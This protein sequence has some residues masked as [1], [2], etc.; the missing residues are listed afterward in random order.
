MGSDTQSR[1]GKYELENT[2]DRRDCAGRGDQLLRLRRSEVSD[3]RSKPAVQA[4]GMFTAG[5]YF[6]NAGAGL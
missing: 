5:F 4:A 3:R 1:G 6:S 2:E